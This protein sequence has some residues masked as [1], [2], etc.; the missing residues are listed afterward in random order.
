P[1]RPVAADDRAHPAGHGAEGD[2]VERQLLPVSHGYVLGPPPF[3]RGGGGGIAFVAG[4]RRGHHE[5]PTFPGPAGPACPAG[6]APVSGTASAPAGCGRQWV[7]VGAA[8]RGGREV[9][10]EPEA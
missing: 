3:L 10:A 8:G 1:A 5:L 4:R 2:V 6:L 9:G 7:V